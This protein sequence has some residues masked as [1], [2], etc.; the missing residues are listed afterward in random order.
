[1]VAL[2][3]ALII[4]LGGAAA[5]GG[6]SSSS[7][8]GFVPAPA[9][10]WAGSRGRRSKAI[11]AS[12]V[13]EPPPSVPRFGSGEEDGRNGA[14]LGSV[15][16]SLVKQ[17]RLPPIPGAP[18]QE[19]LAPGQQEEQQGRRQGDLASTPQPF[20]LQTAVLL[21]PFAFEAYNDPPR[22]EGT[23]VPLSCR[24]LMHTCGG[25]VLTMIQPESTQT[26]PHIHPHTHRSILQHT[27]AGGSWAR[28][29]TRWPL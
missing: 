9:T 28:T 4:A 19:V 13:Q 27:Q 1:M 7:S 25:W 17:G 23:Y 6:G 8:M 29:R 12:S 3:L 21:A 26:D 11:T 14:G 18:L 2:L 22:T 15:L 10:R 20:S 24:D 5:R 16:S